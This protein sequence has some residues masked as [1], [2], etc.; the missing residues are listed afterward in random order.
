MK[1][2]YVLAGLVVI[3]L[4][5]CNQ[6]KHDKESAEFFP[7]QKFS[8]VKKLAYSQSSSGARSDGMLYARHFD[9]D[10]LNAL[11]KQKLSLML[12]DEAAAK[13]MTV[14]LVN[15]GA[16]DLLD[17]RKAAVKDYVQDGLRPDERVEIVVGTNP[18]TAHSTAAVMATMSKTDSGNA[19]SDGAMTGQPTTPSAGAEPGK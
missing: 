19:T 3:L 14:Y 17:K 9:G 4:T 16:G 1:L 10:A 13:P 2:T 8:T 12:C 7:D 5:G 11:G 15:V 18:N 6:E